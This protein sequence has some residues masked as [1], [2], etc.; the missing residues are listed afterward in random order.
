L[1]AEELIIVGRITGLFGVKG[2]VK[3]YSH[4]QPRDNIIRYNPWLLDLEGR[5]QQYSVTEVRRHGKSLIARF[6]DYCTRDQVVG[7]LGA[8]VAISAAQLER[9]PEGEYYWVDL[10]GLRVINLQGIKLG[11]VDHF[12]ETGA[13]DVLV[14][15]G[16]TEILIPYIEART[17]K[18]VDIER[19]IIQVDWELDWVR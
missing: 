2:W 14:V 17:I 16:V 6:E 12:I 7:I 9:L 1:A 18:L 5:W 13:N 8:D 10:I 3:V 4:T 11:A 15:K 19:G